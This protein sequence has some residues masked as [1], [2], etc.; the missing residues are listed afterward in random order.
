MANKK[1]RYVFGLLFLTTAVTQ[2]SFGQVANTEPWKTTQLMPPS[3][4]AA[5]INDSNAEKPVIFSIGPAAII[6]GSI[7]IGP[8]QENEAL[9][10]LKKQL[11]LL[12]KNAKIVIYCGCCPFEHCPNI[13][14]AFELLNK[15]KFVNSKLLS[16]PK[17][18]KVDWIDKGYPT[19]KD[20]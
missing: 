3:E 14:P 2:I 10:E 13:R 6:K 15:M 11:S 20:E 16:L 12:P 7:D 19:N 9:K 5:V 8:A 17:N 1:R 18:I 4:L